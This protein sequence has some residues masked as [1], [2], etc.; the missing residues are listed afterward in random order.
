MFARS[1]ELARKSARSSIELTDVNV[2]IG[3]FGQQKI[4]EKQG[5]ARNEK[6]ALEGVIAFLEKWRRRTRRRAPVREL[7]RRSARGRALAG[8]E[9]SPRLISPDPLTGSFVR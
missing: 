4:D 9:P 3:E 2:A 7:A 8:D 5:D 1:L 6:G